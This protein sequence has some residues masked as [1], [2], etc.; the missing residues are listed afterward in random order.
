MATVD[1]LTFICVSE[2]M[3]E[4]GVAYSFLARVVDELVKDGLQVR[5]H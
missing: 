1:A 3:F 4:R 5:S 2:D